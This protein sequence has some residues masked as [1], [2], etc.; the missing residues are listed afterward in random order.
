MRRQLR[1]IAGI[2]GRGPR[3]AVLRRAVA[4][5]VVLVTGASEGIGAATARRLGA[6]GAVVLLVART[7]ARLEQVNDEITRAGGT[8]FVHPADLSDPVAAQALAAELIRRYRRVDVVV[9]NAGRSIRRSVAET[10]DRF[11]D[12]QRTA[13]LNY[14]GPVALL[15]ALLPAMRAAGRGHIV[16]VSTAGL[17]TPAPGWSAYLASK[18]AFDYWLR[19]AA[20]ELRLDGVTTSTVYCGLVR[21]RM[22]AP[23]K[24]FRRVPAAT[25]EEAAA[26]VCRAV[27]S[28]P[29]T[30][31]AWWARLG[32]PTAA[33]F[34][35]TVERGLALHLRYS[36]ATASLRALGRAGL[37]R[38]HPLLRAVLANRR[39]G[40]TLAAALAA[41][42]RDGLALVDAAGPLSIR[43]LWAASAV[44]ARHLAPLASL[45]PA[46]SPGRDG[47]AGR[48]ELAGRVGLVC[49]AGRGF[50]IAA[51]ALGR[52]GVDTVLLPPDTPAG[53]LPELLAAQGIQALVHDGRYTDLAGVPAWLWDGVSDAPLPRARRPGRLTV[54]TS[55]TT[56]A[57]R[58]IQR[59][60]PLRTLLGPVGTHLRLVPL[61][62]GRPVLLAA[63][64]H[65]GYGLAYLAAGLTLGAPLLLPGELSPREAL[66]LAAEYQAETVVALP[67]QLSRL[68]TGARGQVSSLRAIVS[69]AA[70]LPV[71][72][73]ARL[74][75]AFGDIVYNLYGTT[76]AGWAAIATPADLAAA[77]GTVGRA[78]RGVV[79]RIRDAAGEAL[80]PGELGQVHVAGWLP[81][82]R[83]VATGDL[84]H[85]DP[86]GRLLLHGR[87]DDMIVSGGVNV[88][89][90]PVAAALAEH[91]DI[92][93]VRVTA[94]PDPEF[95][96]R[97]RADVQLR[98]GS[99]LTHGG[100]TGV[101]T[102]PPPTAPAAPGHRDARRRLVRQSR[103]IV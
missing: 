35:G 79:L 102:R 91:P 5:R 43:E 61:R 80:P 46:S 27:A 52:L 94:V 55:G 15:L 28:R 40:A 99:T 73:H 48:V 59:G 38:P 3:E 51:V 1:I 93:A 31:W 66:D 32:E 39:Y 62:P 9:S 13:D 74:V 88:Y 8:A 12:V 68:A 4:G 14:L 24:A 77:P 18:A 53:R 65:H 56:G 60:L 100:A 11:H 76:E 20:P 67:I 2:A 25:P 16:N 10:A 95:G 49:G 101:A 21:T 26:L 71:E 83:E 96:Q 90:Q 30:I 75:E 34:K 54:L 22:S 84:G 64:P 98:Q 82:G 78:P 29:R 103:L 86:V 70:P 81:G 36:R 87:I 63:A 58:G 69:G 23:T 17:A 92:A 7:A 41:G 57:P 97:L 45:V 72:L 44:C 47:S 89:P 37:L 85:L 50:V 42:P 6:A 33:A 19:C